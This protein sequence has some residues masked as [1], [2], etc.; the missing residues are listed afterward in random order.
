MSYID[1]EKIDDKIFKSAWWDD[2]DLD[3]MYD[4][5]EDAPEEDVAPVVHAH[6]VSH[7][8]NDAY[9]EPGKYRCSACQGESLCDAYRDEIVLS[10]FCPH[11]GAR[12]DETQKENN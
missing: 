6:W 7:W 11:C 2:R 10:N 4:L 3:V 5:V 8:E 9:T 12:M 1:R